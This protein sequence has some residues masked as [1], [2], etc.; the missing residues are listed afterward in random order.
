[1]IKSTVRG[2]D[3]CASTKSC[4]NQP[5]RLWTL[6][7]GKTTGPA[8]GVVWMFDGSDIGSD[9]AVLMGRGVNLNQH[10]HPRINPLTAYPAIFASWEVNLFSASSCDFRKLMSL[11]NTFKPLNHITVESR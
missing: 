6:V 2:I 5:G 11:L 1:M 8:V 10:Y 7:C 3:S 9:F 4:R